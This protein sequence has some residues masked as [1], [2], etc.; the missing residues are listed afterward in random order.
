MIDVDDNVPII[1]SFKYVDNHDDA[2]KAF[3][4]IKEYC[5][6]VEKPVIATYSE[7]SGQILEVIEDG[8][9]E[10][11]ILTYFPEPNLLP[12]GTY[13]GYLE[14]VQIGLDPTIF[15]RQYIFN[16]KKLGYEFLGEGLREPLESTS[17]TKIGQN[18]KYDW[19]FYYVQL[20]LYMQRMRDTM[21]ISQCLN[22]GDKIKHN[23]SNLYREFV[24]FGWFK[25]ITGMTF[26]EYEEFKSTMPVS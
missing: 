14:T 10:G 13:E 24:E 5:A 1:A 17:I 6:S 7:T 15:D 8:E 4:E 22:A 12:D 9:D 3:K 16:A 11:K 19:K 25:D 18:L 2:H 21:L 23:L 20:G 26:S